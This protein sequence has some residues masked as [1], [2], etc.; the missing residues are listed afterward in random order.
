M[1]RVRVVISEGHSLSN[2]TTRV[3]RVVAS[4][5]SHCTR[6]KRN[7]LTFDCVMRTSIIREI[8]TRAHDT[9][10]IAHMRQIELR[11]IA[12]EKRNAMRVA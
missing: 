8:P 6:R 7:R 9:I 5:A 12:R 11:D 3:V 10:D 2:A 1:A 4:C